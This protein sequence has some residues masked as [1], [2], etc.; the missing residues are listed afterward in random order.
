MNKIEGLRSIRHAVKFSRHAIVRRILEPAG[1]SVASADYHQ[2]VL[3]IGQAT[4]L[5]AELDDHLYY[6]PLLQQA[7]QAGLDGTA[8]FGYEDDGYEGQPEPH[9][10]TEPFNPYRAMALL[11]RTTSPFG[12]LTLSPAL[13]RYVELLPEQRRRSAVGHQ[14]G[15]ILL[16]DDGKGGHRPMTPAE[17]GRLGDKVLAEALEETL[18]VQTYAQDLARVKQLVEQRGDLQQIRELLR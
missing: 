17:I 4:L 18:F 11:L 8:T 10:P 13:L 2:D 16:T 1:P 12:S 3:V 15:E 6:L 7:C 5:M 9:R 14:D